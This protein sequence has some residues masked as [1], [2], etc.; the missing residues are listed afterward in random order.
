[1]AISVNRGLCA[2]VHPYSPM[3]TA[4]DR[5]G[6][7]SCRLR[8][9]VPVVP[10]GSE[11]V[12]APKRKPKPVVGW[13]EWLT[14]P[15]LGVR[16]IK[17]KVDTGA[18]SSALHAF[19][20][21]SFERDGR[22]WVRFKLHPFQKD[23]LTTV[24]AEAPLHC[25]RYI[26]NS[27]GHLSL[28]PVILTT[29]ELNGQRWPIELTLV[30]RDAMGFRMLLGRQAIRAPVSRGAGQVLPDRPG[31]PALPR[32]QLIDPPAADGAAD[33]SPHC[34]PAA[35]FYQETAMK[36]AILS[37]KS[38]LYSTRRLKEAGEQ[39]G[40]EMH[41]VNYLRCYMNITSHKPAVHL[42]GHAARGFRR[43][44][45]ADRRLEDVLWHRRGAA[46]R[47]D[48]RVFRQRVAGDHSLPRQAALPAIAGPPGHRPAGHRIRQ[49]HRRTSTG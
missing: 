18:R 2:I 44:H 43:G 47:N 15:D 26:R 11:T 19:D 28:R 30:R 21:E 24:A 46:V 40:H 16:A 17:A 35:A 23:T 25:E 14:L 49:L 27:G 48:G 29:L 6:T 10:P 20:V 32:E 39:R 36:I 31:T 33:N 1:M 22:R 12:T 8:A 9:R 45:S 5:Q 42:P 34:A 3:A 4:G 13:R 7:I 38:S 41:V 37:Q